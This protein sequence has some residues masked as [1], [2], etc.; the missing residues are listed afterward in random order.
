LDVSS[1]GKRQFTAGEEAADR[2]A[3]QFALHVGSLSVAERIDPA[4][5]ASAE[6][7][8]AR[9]AF[10]AGKLDKCRDHAN[11][12]LRLYLDAGSLVG[13]EGC[14]RMI[15]LSFL[16]ATKTASDGGSDR[17]QEDAANH[18][19]IS[20]HVAEFLRARIPPDQMGLSRAGFFARRAYVNDRLV[21]LLIDQKKPV[22]ALRYAEL[23][24]ARSLQDL[25]VQTSGG[26][27]TP[28]YEHE[29]PRSVL[30]LLDEWP[31]NCAALEYYLT[32]DKAW[33]FLINTQG[34]VK[35][36]DLLG[37]E[38]V[39]RALIGD[40]RKLLNRMDG[41]FEKM[42]RRLLS[43][44]GFDHAWQHELHELYRT[45]IPPGV[46]DELRKAKTVIVVP[47]HILHYVPF[48]ALVSQPD[49]RTRGMY[50]MVDPKFLLDEPFDL[51]YCPSIRVWDR[52]QSRT[53]RPITQVRAV[54][55][56]DFPS[57]P[58]LPGVE[59]DLANLK[60]SFGEKVSDVLRESDANEHRVQE[61]LDQPGMLLFATHGFNQADRPLESFL[62]LSPSNDSDGRLTAHELFHHQ[63]VTDMVVMSA[64]YS[65]L[66]DRSPLPG[67][68]LFGVQRALLQSGARTVVSGLWDVYDGTGPDLMKEFFD[69]LAEGDTAT[70]ALS[71][72]QRAFLRKARLTK[73]DPY[74][75]PY[76]WSVFTVTG[77]N[78]TSFAK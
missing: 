21:G 55:I 36:F 41:M 35:A 74:L 39:P 56:V 64:C 18:L 45:L 51:V 6:E 32:D 22:E 3:E 77:D 54:A 69:R 33:L 29:E 38:R 72:S 24:K 71:T 20:L 26:R 37:A 8:L 43:G 34:D 30:Q 23:A 5:L 60:A 28:G 17:R 50:E 15:G 65:G 19:L 78:R 13:V 14:H 42:R 10:R 70:A 1:D 75:H 12:A 25:L 7:I 63:V 47:H 11:R 49:E 59:K 44:R 27:Q 31:E 2:I 53:P 58:S 67:D 4:V 16:R 61:L 40:V 57:A 48:A 62:L 52:L 76:F 68:D 66:A 46:L 9:L 73:D